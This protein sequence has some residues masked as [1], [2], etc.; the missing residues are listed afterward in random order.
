[1]ATSLLVALGGL[2]LGWLVYKDVKKGDEDPLKKPLGELYRT[3]QSKY[4]FDEFYDRVFV[5]PAY[6]LAE[7]FSYLWL[8]RKIID[9]TLHAVSRFSYSVGIFFRDFIDGPIVNGFG[10]LLGEGVK[11]MGIVVKGIQTGKIQQYMVIAL[12]IAFAAL[13]FIAFNVLP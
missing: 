4:Y 12:V 1:L 5:Q 7:T 10:D 11:K 9:G 3:W 8:D 13:F 2:S 6:W